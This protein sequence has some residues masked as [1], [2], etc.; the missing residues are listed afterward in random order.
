MT[1][2]PVKV[3]A[4]IPIGA[5]KS[6]LQ[7]PAPQDFRFVETPIEQYAYKQLIVDGNSDYQYDFR[8]AVHDGKIHTLEY[9]GNL[10]VPYADGMTF[11]HA[12]ERG[13]TIL[14]V[15]DN[16]SYGDFMKD[17]DAELNPI[18]RDRLFKYFAMLRIFKEGDFYHRHAFENFEITISGGT[19]KH[20]N[21]LVNI[22]EPTLLLN[23]LTITPQEA[24]EFST[25]L[26]D[27]SEIY[28]L[29]ENIFIKDFEYSYRIFDEVTAFKNIISAMEAVLIP[30]SHRNGS[31]KYPLGNNAACLIENDQS[32]MFALAQKVAGFYENRNDAMHS[33][34]RSG[35]T[36]QKLKEVQEIARKIIKSEFIQAKTWRLVHPGET[37]EQFKNEEM[38]RIEQIRDPLIQSGV[39]H[40]SW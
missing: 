3:I 39:L 16:P 30:N 31:K 19:D 33:G 12:L 25:F 32:K 26:S 23:P 18:L 34:I 21:R 28:D 2:Y 27:Y 38:T 4:S 24:L 22:D 40:S 14:F 1:D 36:K 11:I 8:D 6:F 37:F 7:L 20:F 13:N 9:S 35:I 17:V 5:D 29:L 15:D 10:M